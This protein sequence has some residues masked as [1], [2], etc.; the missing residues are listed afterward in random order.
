M[1]LAEQ[2]SGCLW[3]AGRAGEGEGSAPAQP[4]AL[5]SVGLPFLAPFQELQVAAWCTCLLAMLNCPLMHPPVASSPHT[6]Q[7][8]PLGPGATV[9]AQT[10]EQ[11][12]LAPFAAGARPAKL[13]MGE[14]LFKWLLVGECGETKSGHGERGFRGLPG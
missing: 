4:L 10:E 5:P 13:P 11:V 9:A 8:L 14:C 6:L 2:A 7:V 3:D 12:E 1:G